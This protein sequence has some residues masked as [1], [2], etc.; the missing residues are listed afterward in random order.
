MCLKAHLAYSRLLSSVHHSGEECSSIRWDP[1]FESAACRRWL[2][3]PASPKMS[4]SL[5]LWRLRQ[6]STRNP[7][8]V[9]AM[10]IE[11]PLTLC[12]LIAGRRILSLPNYLGYVHDPGDKDFEVST[13]QLTK[14][15]KHLAGVLNHFWKRWRSEY[16]NELRERYRYI[17]RNTK[18]THIATSD[19]IVHDESLPHGL[20][21]LGW[22]QEV[23]PG[24]DG[25]PHSAL[26]RVASRNKQHTFLKRPVQ[27]LYPLEIS[28]PEQPDNTL[29][30][31]Q[32][33]SEDFWQ[34]MSNSIRTTPSSGRC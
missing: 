8:Q 22:V 20:W 7:S 13:S 30:S 32:R 23:F 3:E 34:L 17:A 24:A 19:V 15:I 26:V 4:Y 16:L 14:R 28:Q 11:E 25:L 18:S 31:A 1:Q 33:Q 5:Q 6:L 2:G 9:S 21:K 10:D 29:A 12:H 27:L